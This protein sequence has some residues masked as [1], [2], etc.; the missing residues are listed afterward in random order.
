MSAITYIQGDCTQPVG[1]G[2]K[3]VAHCCN[4]LGVWGSGFVLALS[5]RWRAPEAAMRE[6]SREEQA[7]L[8]LGGVQFVD[9]GDG[10]TVANIIGQQ[11]VSWKENVPPVR[12]PALSRGLD[13]VG[14]RA[15]AT[16]ASVHVPRLGCDRAGGRWDLVE[17]ILRKRILGRGVPL[18]V[19]DFVP[20]VMSLHGRPKGTRAAET[21]NRRLVLEHT[22]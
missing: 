1:L 9:V 20:V 2:P 4:N 21:L 7:G 12:Y 15:K 14:I 19:Y 6:W 10:I 11:G 5:A 16:G 13:G 18:F 22:P 3:I 17:E 8:P